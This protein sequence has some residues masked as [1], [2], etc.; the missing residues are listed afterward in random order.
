MLLLLA[1]RRRSGTPE[2]A[3]P[4]ISG[5]FLSPLPAAVGVPITATAIWAGFPRVPPGFQWELDGVEIS[6]ATGQT[7]TPVEGDIGGDLTCVVTIDNGVGDPDSAESAAAEVTSGAST[8]GGFSNG[9]SSGFER[10]A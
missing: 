3:A 5:V 2:D 1:R 9:F 6:G 10:A 7:Y 4:S 8:T